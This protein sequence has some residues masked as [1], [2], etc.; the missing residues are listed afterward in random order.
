MPLYEYQCERCGTVF[1][2]RQKF[3]DEPLATHENCGGTVHKLISAPTFQFKGSGWY[4]TDYAKK[5]TSSSSNGEGSKSDSS[6]PKADTSS[7][8]DTKSNEKK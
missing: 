5:S 6:A 1:E 8:S 2:V 7:K 4:A 3:S